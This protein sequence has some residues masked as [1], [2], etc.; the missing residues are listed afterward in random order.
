MGAVLSL[1]KGMICTDPTMAEIAAQVAAERRL[2]VFEMKGIR[3][4]ALLAHARQE[5]M[6]R[7][8]QQGRW[9]LPQIGRFFNRDHTTVLH[10]IRA[11]ARRLE[12]K[13]KQ[14]H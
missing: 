7:M 13:Q 5:A 14:G 8:R 3:R 1:W 4:D 11:Y 6:W 2:S 12:E 9:T 10:G